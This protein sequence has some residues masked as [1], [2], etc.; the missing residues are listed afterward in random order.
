VIFPEID[1]GRRERITDMSSNSASGSSP[2][3]WYSSGAGFR[4]IGGVVVACEVGVRTEVHR[5]ADDG[6]TRGEELGV[7]GGRLA[8]DGV[9]RAD[10]GVDLAGV[11]AYGRTQSDGIV[12]PYDA[13]HAV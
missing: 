8:R 13:P 9:D 4:C 7:V 11:R 5:Q 2:P 1:R 6:I 10:D 3:A 12:E